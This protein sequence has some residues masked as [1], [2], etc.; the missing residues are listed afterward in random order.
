MPIWRVLM[1]PVIGE[2]HSRVGINMS[3][4]AS[5]HQSAVDSTSNSSTS[6]SSSPAPAT[7][8]P[9]AQTPATAGRPAA[10]PD[11][12]WVGNLVATVGLIIGV[13]IILANRQ[14]PK[15]K[16]Y[17]EP[18]TFKQMAITSQ[19]AETTPRQ[20]PVEPVRW[21]NDAPPLATVP[22]TAAEIQ[23]LQQQW[24]DYLGVPVEWK[25][26]VGIS[27]VLVP[28]G[29][30]RMGGTAEQLTAGFGVVNQDDPH[31]MS[32]YQ[33]ASPQHD[34]CL[35]RP[36]YISRYEITQHEFETVVG[37][38]PAWHAATG[39]EPYYRDQVKGI[40]TSP[41]PVEGVSWL[42]CVN[43]C[44][45]LSAL[46]NKAI[47]Y[48][49]VS[50]AARPDFKT[51]FNEGYRL[52]SEAEWEMACR[53][54]TQTRFWTGEEPINAETAGWHGKVH[55]SR[56][57]QVGKSAAN[58]LGVYEMS[59]NV[60]EWVDDYFDPSYYEHCRDRVT[61]DPIG[62]EVGSAMRIVRGGMWPYADTAAFD[63]YAYHND[64]QCNY[65]GFRIVLPVTSTKLS[66]SAAPVD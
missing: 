63:R 40:E 43:F 14:P 5:N 19:A 2:Q 51:L 61:V 36:Y 8:T 47:G 49:S 44:N 29:N 65:V 4:Q 24:A 55:G 6:N 58:A 13:F 3:T 42:D 64:F 52:P 7:Q 39:R 54:G 16:L 17:V 46:E 45:R 10:R 12:T 33:S 41:H 25:N 50:A 15:D 9:A 1:M 59:H 35:T 21:P 60:W 28:P 48:Q 66:N 31:W 34:V 23:S 11:Y 38:N 26:S 32:C 22:M 27:F 18:T 53:A 57:H 56:S 20:N 62:G 30:F 37:N